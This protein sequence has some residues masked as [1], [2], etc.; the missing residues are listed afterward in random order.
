VQYRKAH[1]ESWN[2]VTVSQKP[3]RIELLSS[4]SECPLMSE[5]ISHPD[6]SHKIWKRTK[7]VRNNCSEESSKRNETTM[8]NKEESEK[9]KTPVK[10]KED[11]EKKAASEAKK[12]VL[13]KET[14][15]ATRLDRALK[16]AKPVNRSSDLVPL[17]RE[18]DKMRKQLRSLIVAAKHYHAA[19]VEVE[20]AR[21]EVRRAV[22]C[23]CR[24][25]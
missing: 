14:F 3:Q 11:N 2:G 20:K 9:K 4:L 25:Q 16:G 18:F 15:I 1:R 12:V 23:C 17:G 6:P 7:I 5:V 24:R 22:C 8:T 13:T 10:G 19:R 21:M